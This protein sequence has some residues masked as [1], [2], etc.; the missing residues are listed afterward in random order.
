M[1]LV[2][3]DGSEIAGAQSFVTV[4]ELDAYALLR[5]I[6]TLPAVETEKEALLILGM[7][8]INTQESKFQGAR[9]TSTQI[10]SFPRNGVSMFGF[11][12]SSASV[13]QLVKDAQMQ[14]AI[15]AVTNDLIPTGAGRETIREKVGEIEVEYSSVKGGTIQPVFN[16]VISLLEPIFEIASGSLFSVRV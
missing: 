8:F 1:A 15:E 11:P 5:N 13:P 3:E 7:D 2:I 6:T 14:I 16:K 9:N 4:A 10:L 12:F